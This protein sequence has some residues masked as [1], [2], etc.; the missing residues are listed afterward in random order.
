MTTLTAY[1]RARYTRQMQLEGWS[2]A[3]QEKLKG[4]RVFVAGAGGLGSPVSIYLAAAGIGEIRICDSDRVDL[5]N[6][7]RQI[8]H[9][10][11]RI[12]ELKAV[13]AKTSL[14]ALNP[15]IHIVA[16][17]E[18]LDESNVEQMVRGSDIIVDCLDNMETRHCLSRYSIRHRIPMVHGAIWGMTGQ[19]SF[20]HPPE[21][22]CL[23]CLFP[24]PAPKEVFPVVGM[25]PGFIGCIQALEVVKYLTGIGNNLKGRLLVI[26]G[27]DME[28][29]VLQVASNP[30][31]PDCENGN[32]KELERR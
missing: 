3:G 5:S 32:I 20:L 21:T 25:T 27:I 12:G 14:N 16:L 29:Q 9:D 23:R 2:E 15:A 22:P 31:C 10:D 6:L 30:E 4:A 28:C 19:V 7:N 24:T 13:S 17:P 26:E 11:T 1:D 18:C 8:L